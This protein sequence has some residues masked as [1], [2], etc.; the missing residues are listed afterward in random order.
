MKFTFERKEFEQFRKYFLNLEPEYWESLNKNSVYN[1][2]I[3]VP[4][5][6]KNVVTM[7]NTS[8]IYEIKSMLYNMFKGNKLSEFINVDTMNENINL[9]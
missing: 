3:M 4:I 5:G 6:H 7:F 2:K 8:E 9:N 1:R